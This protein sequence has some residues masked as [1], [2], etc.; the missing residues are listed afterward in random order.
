MK[1]LLITLVIAGGAVAGLQAV[2]ATSAEARGCGWRGYRA[3]CCPV[4]YRAPV[5]CPQYYRVVQ[6]R[7]VKVRKYRR[8]CCR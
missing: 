3:A 8:R 4:Y 1:K 7:V 5:C 2:S 6:Y